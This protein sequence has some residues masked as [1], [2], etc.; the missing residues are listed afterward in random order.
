MERVGFFVERLEKLRQTQHSLSSLH[1]QAVEDLR[2]YASPR[3][4]YSAPRVPAGQSPR[5]SLLA[6]YLGLFT[7]NA[8]PLDSTD[9]TSIRRPEELRR[10]GRRATDLRSSEAEE[11]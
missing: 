7:E 3:P 6:L 9:E 2:A 4:V 11:D 1:T 8:E 10:R 5:A